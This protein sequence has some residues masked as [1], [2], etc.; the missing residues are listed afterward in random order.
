[1]KTV[2]K[3]V[4]GT[5]ETMFLTKKPLSGIFDTLFLTK[6]PF[7]GNYCGGEKK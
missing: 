2:K 1:M 3:G 6:M 7:S 4:S 5:P